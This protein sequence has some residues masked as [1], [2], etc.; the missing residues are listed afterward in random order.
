M[1]GLKEA[2][3]LSNLRL[4]SLLQ[5]FDFHQ[6]LTPGLFRHAS[7][8]I[9]FVLVVDDFGV[10][11]HNPSDFAF[12]VSCLSSLYQVKAHPIASKFLGF[13]IQHDRSHHIFTVSYPG[14]IS[15]LLTRL[16]RSPWCSPH[17]LPLHLHPSNLRLQCPPVSHCPR[18]FPPSHTH[19]NQRTSGSHRLPVVLR[20]CRR[21]PFPPRNL[22]TQLRAGNPHVRNHAPPRTPPRIRRRPPQRSQSLPCLRDD[23]AIIL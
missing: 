2:G 8:A 11:Y 20:S 13:S 7:R 14:Y 3:K 22:R 6:T 23:L 12:L 16:R 19:P 21:R 1:Y 18:H 5:S 10:Q 4:V 17:C 15:T 9:T